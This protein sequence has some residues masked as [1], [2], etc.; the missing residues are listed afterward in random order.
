MPEQKHQG[1]RGNTC[2]GILA[3]LIDCHCMASA[4]AFSARREGL[5]LEQYSNVRFVTGSLDIRYLKPSP[6]GVPVLLI[7]RLVEVRKERIYTLRCDL[8]SRKEKT[9]EARVVAFRIE[10]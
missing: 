1:W 6:V 10:C 7:S 5:A 4:M 9:V 2:G 8:F 3:T